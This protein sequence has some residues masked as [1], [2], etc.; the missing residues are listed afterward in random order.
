MICLTR[1]CVRLE[2]ERKKI[3]HSTGTPPYLICLSAAPHSPSAI[4]LLLC[5]FIGKCIISPVGESFVLSSAVPLILLF[6][7][8]RRVFV[9]LLSR[10]GVGGVSPSLGEGI[11]HSFC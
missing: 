1:V 10:D 3:T 9:P 6:V 4:P 11:R 7:V 5:S 8:E 2:G